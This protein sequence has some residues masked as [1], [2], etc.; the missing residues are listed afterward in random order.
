MH[1]ARRVR[2]RE[3][4]HRLCCCCR[5]RLCCDRLCCDRLRCR[6]HAW[7]TNTGQIEI[8]EP[9]MERDMLAWQRAFRKYVP[10]YARTV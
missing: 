10:M 1:A 8:I 5:D 3:A 4:A 7:Y 9:V 6:Y 2:C